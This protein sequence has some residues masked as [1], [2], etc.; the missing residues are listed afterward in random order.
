MIEDGERRVLF[1][2]SYEGRR[3]TERY[4]GLYELYYVSLTGHHER[5]RLN[6]IFKS[7]LA[8]EQVLQLKSSGMEREGLISLP[9]QTERPKSALVG[10]I[11]YRE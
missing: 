10:N 4:W 3:R 8:R 2:V 5:S 6:P 9:F 11:L 1:G 7:T